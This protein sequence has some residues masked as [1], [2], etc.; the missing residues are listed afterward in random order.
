MEKLSL[1][2]T[3]FNARQLIHGRDASLSSC[4]GIRSRQ[5]RPNLSS[6]KYVINQKY[7]YVI[8]SIMRQ[9][10]A[11]RREVRKKVL[12]YC[13]RC[14]ETQQVVE[15]NSSRRCHRK[16]VVVCSFRRDEFVCFKCTTMTSKVISSV[17]EECV[18]DH[19]TS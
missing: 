12:K 16:R 17:R 5:I 13:F 3:E 15:G 2:A 9:W 10:N 1:F 11:D 7:T 8:D 19:E 6:R 14:P 4:S 18:S